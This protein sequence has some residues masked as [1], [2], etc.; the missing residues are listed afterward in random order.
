[1]GALVCIS[2]KMADHLRATIAAGS[3][4]CLLSMEVLRVE[5]MLTDSSLTIEATLLIIEFCKIGS[6]VQLKQTSRAVGVLGSSQVHF[7]KVLGHNAL[8]ALSSQ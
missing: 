1:M 6:A 3:S 4:N 8:V 2:S 5:H 7:G